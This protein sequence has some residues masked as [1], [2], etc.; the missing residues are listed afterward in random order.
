MSQPGL[1]SRLGRL[2][3][4]LASAGGGTGIDLS[5]PSYKETCSRS[6]SAAKATR[7][8]AA[9]SYLRPCE[10]PTQA[11]GAHNGGVAELYPSLPTLFPTCRLQ[12]GRV[13]K[14]QGFEIDSPWHAR[15]T[16]T[17]RRDPDLLPSKT[18]PS[19]NADLA[20]SLQPNGHVSRYVQYLQS[21]SANQSRHP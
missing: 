13:G 9:A 12:H 14:R 18:N 7:C 5:L 20:S 16:D 19:I 10:L 17:C 3:T 11:P 6:H 1:R 8:D 2:R 15:T 21:S 4:T